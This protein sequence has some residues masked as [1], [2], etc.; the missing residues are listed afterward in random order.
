LRR[1]QRPSQIAKQLKAE[2][3]LTPINY[4]YRQTGVALVNLDTTRTYNWSDTS[5]ANILCDISCLGHT[6]NLRY[7]TVSY[8]NKKQMDTPNLFSGMV[9]CADC[10]GKLVL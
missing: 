1:G 9:Y 10:G 8:K 5:I 3:V 7:T 4:Y 2:Q 6:V